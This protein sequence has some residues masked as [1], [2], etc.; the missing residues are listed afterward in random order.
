M[1]TKSKGPIPFGV[2]PS[3]SDF[4]MVPL[5]VHNVSIVLSQ[6]LHHVILKQFHSMTLA[7]PC[8]LGNTPAS[9]SRKD[10]TKEETVLAN[11]RELQSA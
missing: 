5:R 7:E 2:E 8:V 9:R 6:F 11:L 1:I 10:G 3:A 4:A